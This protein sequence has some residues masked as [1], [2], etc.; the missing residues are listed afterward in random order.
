MLIFYEIDLNVFLKRLTDKHFRLSLLL[1]LPETLDTVFDILLFKGFSA[2][3]GILF[4]RVFNFR[5]LHHFH[6]AIG[7]LFAGK[8]NCYIGRLA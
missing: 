2:K 8:L 1:K 7:V 3:R 6:L 5:A 4:D